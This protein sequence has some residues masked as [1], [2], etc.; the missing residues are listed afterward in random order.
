L[1]SY[2]EWGR[3]QAVKVWQFVLLLLAAYSVA[4]FTTTWPVRGAAIFGVLVVLPWIV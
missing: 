3:N 4:R 2:A 1:E